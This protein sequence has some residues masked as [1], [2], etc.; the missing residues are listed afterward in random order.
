M[1]GIKIGYKTEMKIKEILDVEHINLIFQ[2]KETLPEDANGNIFKVEAEFRRQYN[3]H[4]RT[5]PD[6]EINDL[7]AIKRT[8]LGGNLKFKLE[9][10][11][12]YRVVKKRPHNRCEIEKVGWHEYLATTSTAAEIM[13]IWSDSVTT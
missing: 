12:P 11:G 6:K 4:R 9:F 3:K 5:A 13:K 1:T 7:V 8:Q 10:L 2:K